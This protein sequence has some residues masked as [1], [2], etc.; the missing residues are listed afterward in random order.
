MTALQIKALPTEEKL[1]IMEAI[2]E[3][4]RDRYEN[5]HVPPEVITLLRHRQE[6]VTKGEAKFLDWDQVKSAIG[7]G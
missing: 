5:A 3:D 1:R 4:M 6:R 2:W 7:R